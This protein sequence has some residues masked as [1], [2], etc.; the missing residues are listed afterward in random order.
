M[1]GSQKGRGER[2]VVVSRDREEGRGKRKKGKEQRGELR[3]ERGEGSVQREEER[4]KR[5][6]GGGKRGEKRW[7][8]QT[9]PCSQIELSTRS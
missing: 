2:G 4:R 7:P 1:R 3:V 6:E 5:D 9:I 8:V